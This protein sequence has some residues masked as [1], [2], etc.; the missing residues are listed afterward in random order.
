MKIS[1]NFLK[2]FIDFNINP[3]KLVALMSSIGLEATFMSINNN[4]TNIVTAEIVNISKHPNADRLSLCKLSDGLKDYSIICGANN[5][6][7][8]QIVPLAKIGAIVN[9]MKVKPIVIRGI[10]SEGMI[11][12]KYELGLDVN[13]SHGILILDASTKIGLDF[14][15]VID[16][17]DFLLNIEIPSNRG[18][19]L[20]YI[21]LA[22]EI[23]AKLHK[24]IKY[25][26]IKMIKPKHNMSLNICIQSKLCY[27]YIG[28]VLSGIKISRS[29]EW[30]I[31]ILNKSDIRSIN[32]IVDITN[33]VMLETGQP[34]HAFDINSFKSSNIIIR[35]AIA[36][37][38][39]LTI[40][41]K[42]HVLDAN[43][44]VLSSNKDILSIAGIIGGK[45][46]SVTEKTS[47]ILLESAMF[48]AISIR[49]T[50]KKFNITSQASYRFE[51]NGT[52]WNMID[53]ASWRAIN[54]IIQITGAKIE[55]QVDIK[56][57]KFRQT[58]ILLNLKKIDS[59]LGYHIN[60]HDILQI[61][62]YLGI[63]ILLTNSVT[64]TC[65]IP[66][67]RSDI[68]ENIDLI[69]EIAR[70][71]GYD[72]IPYAMIK[73]KPNHINANKSFLPDIVKDMRITLKCLGFHEV[74]NSS[75]AEIA[76]LNKFHLDYF[77][78]IINPISKE[79]EV[80]RPS[81][82]PSMY[83]NLL[84][85]IS[86]GIDSISLFEY[87]KTFNKYSENKKF[88]II[89]YGKIWNE[90]W[91]WNDLNI[92]PKY[93]FY[94]C[95]GIIKHILPLKDIDIV[96]NNIHKSYYHPDQVV[97]IFHH[98]KVVGHFGTLDPSITQHD[99]IQG[100]IFYCEINTDLI[101]YSTKTQILRYKQYS[102]FPFVKRDISIV[103]NKS[104]KF[105]EIENVI[106]DIIQT[107]NIL[108]QYSIFSV[109]SNN[110][111]LGNN[112]ISYSIR[113]LYQNKNR[114]LTNKEVDEDVHNLLQKLDNNLGIKLR[115]S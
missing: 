104:L 80:L 18:D 55:S 47:S 109:Y 67:W 113:L 103:A 9:K 23:G 16:N 21:G 5:I 96:K 59:V 51:R 20:N 84:S 1:Y 17:N 24:S 86:H 13:K 97:S 114:T 108:K 76:D 22:R 90:W 3:D 83:N 66:S 48:D 14:S 73:R 35:N 42:Q 46:S 92:L 8:G 31:E 62:K 58:K 70:I 30:L 40:E 68:T 19:C 28:T 93:D 25:P 87:G 105:F 88:A 61:L 41:N 29:P 98:N 79:N 45:D 10:L 107:G 89:M 34:L 4:Y 53:F 102:K 81:L 85:N 94:F 57:K 69:E 38:T 101:E 77:Y 72:N 106:N 71:H 112:K 99:H 115:Q 91:K 37:E 75:F 49:K 110:K 36:N 50:S 27:R 7:I 52:D 60:K 56:R 6:K 11:C 43:D 39:I 82:L 78:K 33:Y 64:I 95:G 54:L 111:L 63:K 32:N 74:L 12:S 15:N 100:D 44:I 26:N 2:K 65:I